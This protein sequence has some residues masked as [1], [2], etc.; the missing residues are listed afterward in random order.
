ME[1]TII[2]RNI[3]DLEK[4]FPM[5]RP[6][7]Y[8]EQIECFKKSGKPSKSVDIVAVFIF[9]EHGEIFIQKRA[10]EKAHNP[11]LLDKT[12]G[13]HVHYGDATEYTVMVETVQE[14][15]VPSIVLKKAQDY[16]KTYQ[17][18]KGYLNTIAI[19]KHLDTKL[20]WLK[21]VF[22]KEHIVIANYV[23]LFLGL[24]GGRIK[25]VDREATGILQYQLS[26][27]SDEM[28]DTPDIFTNDLHVLIENYRSELN[29]FHPP[30]V[31][32]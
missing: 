23:H 10:K 12:L 15:Q 14:L 28:K 31:N 27:L 7:F 22:D 18:L 3:N 9:N 2:A 21:K 30:Q 26:D 25:T 11:K 16:K 20:F 17:L 24:Y 8:K 5:K 4:S 13:G 19:I 29:K 6:Q 1:E 32:L